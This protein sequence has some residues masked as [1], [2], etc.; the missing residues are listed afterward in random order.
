M[1]EENVET[2]YRALRLFNRQVLG[3]FLA[4]MAVQGR[5]SST[6]GLVRMEG[7]FRGPRRCV[8]GERTWFGQRFPSFTSVGSVTSAT[9]LTLAH[10]AQ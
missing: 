5:D 10:P 7:G 8:A 9:I 6:P 4:L 3:G 2:T 1:S